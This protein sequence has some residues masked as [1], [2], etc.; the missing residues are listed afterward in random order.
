MLFGRLGTNSTEEK[1]FSVNSR[2]GILRHFF[3]CSL[4]SCKR[5]LLPPCPSLRETILGRGRRLLCFFSVKLHKHCHTHLLHDHYKSP[6]FGCHLNLN[7]WKIK[8][9]CQVDS[10]LITLSTPWS[11]CGL[12][13]RLAVT[14]PGRMSLLH[15]AASVKTAAESL[16]LCWWLV[17]KLIEQTFTLYALFCFTYIYP[18]VPGFKWHHFY[19]IPH[20]IIHSILDFKMKY[21]LV[22]SHY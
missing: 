12:F 14:P 16:P 18:S 3:C 19:I 11:G 10:T 17:L 9:K 6:A 21:K 20:K 7:R 5:M 1:L 2:V 15:A 8:F 22:L 13:T 4:G